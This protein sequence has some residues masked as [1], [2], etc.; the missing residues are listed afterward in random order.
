MALWRLWRSRQNTLGRTG[1]AD[2]GAVY[3]PCVLVTTL[4]ANQLLL[5]YGGG[6][7]GAILVTLAIDAA[8]RV[9]LGVCKMYAVHLA[10]A[11]FV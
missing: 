6:S 5:V 2:D 4:S 11:T 9:I 8:K 3:N 1:F 7:Y 10:T